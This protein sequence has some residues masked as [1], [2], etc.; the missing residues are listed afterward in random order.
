MTGPTLIRRDVP[1]RVAFALEQAGV[2]PL[3]ARLFAARGVTDV[4]FDGHV[5][6]AVEI[7]EYATVEANDECRLFDAVSRY[8]ETHARAAINDGIA[9]TDQAFRLNHSRNS[10]TSCKRASGSSASR[11]SAG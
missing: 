6:A 3:L 1:P 2:H 8:R 5:S 9:R 4:E 11:D 10:S 7:G